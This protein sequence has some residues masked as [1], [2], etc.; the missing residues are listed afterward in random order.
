MAYEKPKVIDLSNRSGKG[1]GEGC[2]SGSGEILN[3]DDGLTA[4]QTCGVG[5]AAAILPKYED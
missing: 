4:E 3:C 1:F 2:L 5:N